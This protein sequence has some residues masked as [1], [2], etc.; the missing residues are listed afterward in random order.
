M[1]RSP[2]LSPFAG[3]WRSVSLLLAVCFFSPC[4]WAASGNDDSGRIIALE[5]QT[6]DIAER[7]RKLETVVQGQGLVSLL[8]QVEALKGEVNKL[9][10]QLEVQTYTIETTQKRQND[11]YADLDERMRELTQ[12]V[13]TIKGP[14]SA[15]LKQDLTLPQ[16]SSVQAAPSVDPLAE[17]KAYDAALNYY[18]VGN[19]KAA[20]VAFQ[21]FLKDYPRS[22]LSANAQFWIGQSYFSSRDFRSALANQQKLVILYPTS[23]KVADALLNIA[24]S[25]IELGDTEG[26]KA[27]LERLITKHPGTTA[28]DLAQK[29]LAILK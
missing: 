21:N 15:A 10:G 6:R 26:A 22:A 25:Q 4:I 9:R 8:A 24:S 19:Y 18:K 23:P 12:T 3:S 27:T 1:K 2:I 28:A 5:A 7:L 17:A 29:R 13:D 11:L 16:Q 14:K 20:A